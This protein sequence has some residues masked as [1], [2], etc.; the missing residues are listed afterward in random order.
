MTWTSGRLPVRNAAPLV[1]PNTAFKPHSVLPAPGMPVTNR[2]SCRNSA[3]AVSTARRIASV[4]R[5]RLPTS[6][7][8]SAISAT[9]CRLYSMV[10]ASTIVGTGRYGAASQARASNGVHRRRDACD[11]VPQQRP[12]RCSR[13]REHRRHAVPQ[14]RPLWWGACASRRHQDRHD[15]MGAALRVEVEEI[16][17]VVLG[18]LAIEHA[19]RRGADLEF[20]H[21]DD[22]LRS[23]GPHRS[24]VPGEAADIRTGCARC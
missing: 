22:V 13:R 15:R 11:N 9:P 3:R 19:D 6:A 23:A 24:A 5:P 21:D 1:A 20:Q 18:L 8:A 12:Q 14:Q 10:A 7:R 16:E 17:R 4:V 2:T